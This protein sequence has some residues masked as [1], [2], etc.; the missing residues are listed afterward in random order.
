MFHKVA[1][2]NRGTI[3]ARIVRALRELKILSHVLCSEVDKSNPYV[4]EADSFTVIGPASPKDS[5]L[6]M[7]AILDAAS[8]AGA[9]A[10]H[11]GYGFLAENATFAKKV[12]ERGLVFIGPSPSFLE[13]MGDKVL[14]RQRMGDLGLPL[15]PATPI[16][17]GSLEEKVH[18]AR[19]IGF[20]LL[21]KPA[22]G[23]GGIGMLPVTTPE[24]LASAIETAASQAERGFGKS[25]VYAERLL[26]NPRHVEFQ[27]VGDGQNALHLYERDCSIQRRRQKVLEEAGAPEIA[28]EK[29]AKMAITSAEIM[30]KIGY[31]HVGTVETLYSE[32]TGFGFLEVNPRLQVEH[33]VTEEITGV[34]LVKT[35]IELASG[36]K[37]SEL[38][39][40]TPSSSGWA[41]E[42]RI[43]AEDSLR[44]LPSPG[45]LKVF[46]PPQGSSI[47][48]ETGFKE[49]L[50]V[51]PFYD[52]MLAQVIAHASTRVKALELLFEALGEFAI[53]GLKTN[54]GFLRA[55]LRYPVFQGGRPHT[56]LAEEF[57]A[58][59]DYQPL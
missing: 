37:I 47:R 14:A 50:T 15:T 49:G 27:I 25:E 48:V 35:Q 42:A 10:I 58:S 23:G 24:K 54:L 21:I 11:P 29:L 6:N 3:A 59:Q 4:T 30:A 5:Y 2:A 36:K 32:E 51:T 13:I 38:F 8:Q 17:V 46:R 22:G 16:L 26:I 7:E 40:T 57:I 12:R 41:I 34:D 18:S 20:P 56:R 19:A 52:P 39:S 31:D 45:P 33:A 53:E 44:F 1:V 9:E 28:P 55:M 43:Y